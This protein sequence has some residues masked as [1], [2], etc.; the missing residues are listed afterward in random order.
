M[1]HKQ[2]NG[3]FHYVIVENRNKSSYAYWSSF[4]HAS[5]VGKFVYSRI[6]VAPL[7]RAFGIPS[8]LST[9]LQ[10]ITPCT[11]C[12]TEATTL[13]ARHLINIVGIT[14][15]R[16]TETFGETVTLQPCILKPA[17]PSPTSYRL[18]CLRVSVTSLLLSKWISAQQ[19][20]LGIPTRIPLP[21]TTAAYVWGCW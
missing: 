21:S 10:A 11:W 6:D 13:N 9:T 2:N 17:V 8:V 5:F 4:R 16:K 12:N 15:R 14:V 18:Y 1:T 20:S 7:L 3:E 19:Y